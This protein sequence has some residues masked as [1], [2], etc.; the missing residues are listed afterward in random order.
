MLKLEN[1]GWFIGM[2][3][4]VIMAPLIIQS[5]GLVLT[6]LEEFFMGGLCGAVFS[7]AGLLLGGF[8][9]NP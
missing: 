4:A 5:M 9:G 2:I 7:A 1:I 3:A 8:A 6:P